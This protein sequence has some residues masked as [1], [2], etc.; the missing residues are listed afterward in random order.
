[1]AGGENLIPGALPVTS[2]K[3]TSMEI[4]VSSS[5]LVLD[6]GRELNVFQKG[7]LTSVRYR[8]KILGCGSPVVLVSDHGRHIMSSSTVPLKTR[9]VGWRCTL[10]LARAETSCNWC[11]SYERG[12]A[13]SGVVHVT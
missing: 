9:R 3:L 4:V 1:M 7:F 10:D 11:G 8:D 13:S 12:A 5:R 6:G 2:R